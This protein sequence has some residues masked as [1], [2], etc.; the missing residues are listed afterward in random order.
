M[1]GQS[2]HLLLTDLLQHGFGKDGG[3]R[4]PRAQVIDPALALGFASRGVFW[5]GLIEPLNKGLEVINRAL[6]VASERSG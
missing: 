6:F 1:V 4:F 3:H 2:Y 5:L